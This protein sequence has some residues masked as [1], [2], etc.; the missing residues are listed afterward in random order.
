MDTVHKDDREARYLKIVRQYQP[1]E[2]QRF[3]KMLGELMRSLAGSFHDALGAIFMALDLGNHQ[4]GQFFT[5]YSIAYMMAAMTLNDAQSIIDRQSFLTLYEPAVGGGAMV[6]AAAHALQEQGFDYHTAMH[7]T[8]QDIDATAVHMSY[9][10]LAI[11]DIPAIVLHGNALIDA[12]PQDWWVTPA[13][14]LGGWN[15]KLASCR[16]LSN[17][18]QPANAVLPVEQLSLF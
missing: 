8:A 5:P 4:K 3:P 16:A 2:V 18:P 17:A 13:H 15:Q 1:D 7:V 10:Q 6:I 14:V 11:L 9:I 12:P